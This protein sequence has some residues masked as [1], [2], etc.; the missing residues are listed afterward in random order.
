[1]RTFEGVSDGK[2]RDGEA[3]VSPASRLA[4]ANENRLP[5]FASALTYRSA[6]TRPS[7]SPAYTN[8][9]M[10]STHAARR[11]AGTCVALVARRAETRPVPAF[12]THTGSLRSRRATNTVS[13]FSGWKRA[14]TTGGASGVDAA[15]AP[16]SAPDVSAP[17]SPHA[18]TRE[19][20]RESAPPRDI[21]EAA[22][23]GASSSSPSSAFSF[24]ASLVAS[25]AG[26]RLHTRTSPASHAVTSRSPAADQSM[27]TTGAAC[28]FA[29]SARVES[30]RYP[31][32][33]SA[34]SPPLVSRREKVSRAVRMSTLPSAR[35]S[36]IFAGA[37]AR[38]SP[39]H[40]RTTRGAARRAPGESPKSNGDSAS[41]DGF[42]D[43]ASAFAT[44]AG[45]YLVRAGAGEVRPT[46]RLAASTARPD[47]V[48]DAVAD[49]VGS[50]APSTDSGARLSFAPDASFSAKRNVE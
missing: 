20:R 18:T 49:G 34:F 43:P 17:E 12:N 36:A 44:S 2:K 25:E 19:Q 30:S 28:R 23:A 33:S 35:P 21:R 14:A 48:A 46:S 22:R 6:S 5:R 13:A 32:T 45:A 7:V 10:A 40:H 11:S 16:E 24:V 42:S 8:D 29:S 27:S 50:R 15:S 3:R 41:R 31:T 4:P 26:A 39:R 37:P 1:M 9:P 47:V 38:S